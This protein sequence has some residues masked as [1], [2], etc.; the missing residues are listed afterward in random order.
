MWP[1]KRLL[2]GLVLAFAVSAFAAQQQSPT[3][4]LPQTTPPTFPEDRASRQEMPPDTK[5]PPPQPL[6]TAQVEQQIQDKLK[7]EPALAN[8]NVE[9]KTDDK[10]VTLTGTVDTDGQ[11]DVALRIAQSYAGDRKIADKIK[12][13]GQA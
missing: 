6:S 8:T 3:N 5:A 1:M 4:P 9:V 7:S 11:H 2:C 12:V 10:S 13:R